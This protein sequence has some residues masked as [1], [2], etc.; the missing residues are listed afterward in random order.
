MSITS[1]EVRQNIPRTCFSGLLNLVSKILRL[2]NNMTE[3]HSSH[4]LN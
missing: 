3:V 1:L 4:Y 2:L